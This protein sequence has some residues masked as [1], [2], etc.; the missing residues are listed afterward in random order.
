MSIED[1]MRDFLEEH[2]PNVIGWRVLPP[3]EPG[4]A[5][6]LECQ[7]IRCGSVLLLGKTDEVDLLT[8]DGEIIG[9]SCSTCKPL[10][11]A[12]DIPDVDAIRYPRGSEPSAN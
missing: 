11:P 1:D 5:I 9:A 8:D 3:K 4:G 2:P 10:I 12:V 6:L 7:C